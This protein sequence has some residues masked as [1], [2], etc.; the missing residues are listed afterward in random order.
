[1][2][3]FILAKLFKIKHILDMVKW[4]EKTIL[5]LV[6]LQTTHHTDASV[7]EPGTIFKLH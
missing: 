3:W 2:Y 6:D 5:H 1:M 4:E 7:R